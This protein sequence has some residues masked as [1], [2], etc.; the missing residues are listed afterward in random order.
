[1]SNVAIVGAITFNQQLY[2]QEH[3]LIR[4]NSP[5]I[6]IEARILMLEAKECI[7]KTLAKYKVEPGQVIERIN[8]F[9]RQILSSHTIRSAE[10]LDWQP[11]RRIPG[12]EL[13]KNKNTVL[14][15]GWRVSG[16][17]GIDT[18]AA[19][20]IPVNWPTKSQRVNKETAEIL[21]ASD[22][23]RLHADRGTAIR[24]SKGLNNLVWD[25]HY[26]PRPEVY[27]GRDPW[28]ALP[29]IGSI[30][31]AVSYTPYLMRSKP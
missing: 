23:T 11:E 3:G 5:E 9:R 12:Y 27:S 20:V 30:F 8:N 7:E 10:L 4:L 2:A 1:M 19:E 17:D 14:I 24:N 6:N 22:T 21:G 26:P 16:E 29:Y 25:F 31:A 15:R 28:F 13:P 18:R